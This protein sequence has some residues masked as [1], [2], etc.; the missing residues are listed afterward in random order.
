MAKVRYTFD[1]QRRLMVFRMKSDKNLYSGMD[2]KARFTYSYLQFLSQT[3]LYLLWNPG[4][5][6]LW[7]TGLCFPAR[8]LPS[9]RK[10]SV[11]V[12]SFSLSF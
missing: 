9:H 5:N 4:L 12:T 7:K 6:L 10:I 1:S 2:L 8:L 11:F 3:G